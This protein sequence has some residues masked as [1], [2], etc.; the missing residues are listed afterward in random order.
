MLHHYPNAAVHAAVRQKVTGPHYHDVREKAELTMWYMVWPKK[1]QA[2][3]WRLRCVG[4]YCTLLSFE[5][6]SKY[7]V[8]TLSEK[9]FVAEL[10]SLDQVSKVL[11]RK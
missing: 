3:D 4:S 2:I 6:S 9:T 11:L 8:T 1:V 10:Q 5:I 7:S